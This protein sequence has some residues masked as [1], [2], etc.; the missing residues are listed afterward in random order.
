MELWDLYDKNGKSLNK[1][2]DRKDKIPVGEYHLV[3]HIW[4]YNDDGQYLIQKRNKPEG[5][6]H[7]VWACTGGCVIMGE[8]SIQGAIRETEEEMSIS[9]LEKELKFLDRSFTD[10]YIQDVWIAK[11]NGPIE[12][13]DFDRNEVSDVR[14]VH[15]REFA[16]MV[17]SGEFYDYGDRY[18]SLVENNSLALLKNSFS[19]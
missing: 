17:Q 12:D 7:D 6:M 9:F 2:I 19:N 3:C 15:R 1:T 18:L 5:P 13:V 8:S 10:H 14:W 16:G 11:W 4:I